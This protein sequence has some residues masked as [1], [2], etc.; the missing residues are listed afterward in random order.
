MHL[1]FDFISDRVMALAVGEVAGHGAV[2]GEKNVLDRKGNELYV[3][4]N[5]C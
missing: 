1:P 5:T 2:L 3:I 4:Q